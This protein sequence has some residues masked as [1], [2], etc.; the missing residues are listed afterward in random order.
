MDAKYVDVIFSIF[1]SSLFYVVA[2]DDGTHTI[3]FSWETA[4][5][6]SAYKFLT[7]KIL[8]TLKRRGMGCYMRHAL[9]ALVKIVDID[10]ASK[11]FFSGLLSARNNKAIASA[12]AS[13]EFKRHFTTSWSLHRDS[14]CV[15]MNTYVYGH[16]VKLYHATDSESTGERLISVNLLPKHGDIN[17]LARVVVLMSEPEVQNLWQLIVNED[18]SRDAVDNHEQSLVVRNQQIETELLQR[19]FNNSSYKASHSVS[20]A[21][22]SATVAVDPSHPP[23]PG[24]TLAWL[25]EQRRYLRV[26]M[27]ACQTN[28]AKKT[29]GGERGVDGCDVDLQFWRFCRGDP[30]L[31]FMWLHWGRG[32]NVPAHCTALLDDDCRLDIGVGSSTCVTPPRTTK[33]RKNDAVT[34]TEFGSALKLLGNFQ[35]QLLS[36]VPSSVSSSDSSVVAAEAKARITTALTTRI[37]ALEAAKKLVNENGGIA[38]AFSAKIDALV[39]ELLAV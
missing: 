18:R 7:S 13:V 19:Y 6:E 11:S 33:N 10:A 15:P 20:L 16:P 1:I 24:K 2:N 35:E 27:G 30:I 34:D 26:V 25:R 37:Q 39:M 21:A 38:T 31:M 12:Q 32:H 3:N 14:M 5:G 28:F 4:N 23:S 36:R 22:Y 8:G 9:T 17:A 29:G